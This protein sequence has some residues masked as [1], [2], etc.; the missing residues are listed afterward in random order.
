MQQKYLYASKKHIHKKKVKNKEEMEGVHEKTS[1][2][3]GC[4]NASTFIEK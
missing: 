3:P 2:I 4:A 1:K